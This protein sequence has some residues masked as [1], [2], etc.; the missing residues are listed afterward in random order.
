MK[1]IVGLGNPGSQY[2]KT[3]H[4]AGFVAVD[5][6][7]RRWGA[8]GAGGGGGG[9]VAKSRFDGVLWEMEI[10]SERCLLLKP[11][12][13]MNRSGNSVMQALNFYKLQPSANLL[14]LVDEA[15]LPLGT[16][17]LRADGSAGGHNG[18]AD[19]QRA[20]GTQS[21]PRLRIGID[22]PPPPMALHD[23]VLGRFSTEQESLLEPSLIAAA[24]ATECFITSGISAAMN[25]FNAPPSPPS[26]PTTPRSSPSASPS[27][28]A[29]SRPALKPPAPVPPSL[30]PE[31]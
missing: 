22:P 25:K 15:A 5:R 6:L 14:V 9:A 31:P 19:I 18:L 11:L 7:A 21:Y 29:S 24:D 8:G 2:E 16:I 26:P 4:N 20:I 23:W 27:P 12:T 30:T 13:F 28:V 3:R 1:L 17:R 10:K